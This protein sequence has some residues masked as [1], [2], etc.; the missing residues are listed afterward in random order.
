VQAGVLRHELGESVTNLLGQPPQLLADGQHVPDIARTIR[1]QALRP[2]RLSSMLRASVF[3]WRA[4]R[5]TD[6]PVW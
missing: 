3:T 2:I 4:V 5:R 1:T 6:R